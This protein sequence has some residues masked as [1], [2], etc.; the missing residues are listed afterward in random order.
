MG[1]S[2]RLI[3]ALCAHRSPNVTDS[4]LRLAVGKQADTAVLTILVVYIFYISSFL[5]SDLITILE[6]DLRHYPTPHRKL[7]LSEVV[8]SWPSQGRG[9]PS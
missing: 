1:S 6:L 4:Q 7:G 8:G 2:Q 3:C 5:L 9:K